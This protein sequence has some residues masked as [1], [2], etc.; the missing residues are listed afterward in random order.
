MLP[1]TEPGKSPVQASGSAAWA[2][3]DSQLPSGVTWLISDYLPGVP[4]VN[5]PD[6]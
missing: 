3:V 6:T 2:A 1:S 5:E 4:L